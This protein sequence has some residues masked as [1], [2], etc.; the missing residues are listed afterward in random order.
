[1]VTK[2]GKD[3]IV[4]DAPIA[5]ATILV[6]ED[7]PTVAEVV[8]RYLAREGYQVDIESDGAEGLETCIGG[9]T[10]PGGPRPDVAE[11]V[12]TGGLSEAAP[13]GPGPGDN[14]HGPIG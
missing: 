13:G 9:P 5:T 4:L 7:D 2:S 10:R 3:V 6:I 14:A 1:M 12:G 11:P 8:A